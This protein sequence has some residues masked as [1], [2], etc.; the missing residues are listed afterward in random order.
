MTDLPQILTSEFGRASGMFIAG[1]KVLSLI[2]YEYIPLD[3]YTLVISIYI[4]FITKYV[5]MDCLNLCIFAFK[6]NKI[7]IAKVRTPCLLK[8]LSKY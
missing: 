7:N 3:D 1:L 4:Y 8:R 6:F 5:H 2:N